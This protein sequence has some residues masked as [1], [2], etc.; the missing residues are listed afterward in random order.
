MT[1]T[2]VIDQVRP[3]IQ[4]SE[5]PVRYS[6]EVLLSFVNQV[7]HLMVAYRPDLFIVNDEIPTTPSTVLQDLPTGATRIMEIYQVVDGDALQEVNRETLDQMYPAW[8]T[9]TAGTPQNWMRHPRNPTKFFLY[10][11]PSSGIELV[12]EYV[13]SPT[14]LGLTDA[15]D[16]PEAYKTALTYGVVYMAESVDTEHIGDGRTKFFLDSFFEML[17]VDLSTRALIDNEDGRVSAPVS[18]PRRGGE[19]NG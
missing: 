9:E 10:P 17:G 15:I 5:D 13:N 12:A 11:R 19:Q 6:D 2:D 7:L 16:L 1:P 8:R 4:D 18:R 14:D 3:L